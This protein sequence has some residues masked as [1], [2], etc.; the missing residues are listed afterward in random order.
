MGKP[1]AIQD[2]RTDPEEEFE[3]ERTERND[4]GTK[5]NRDR[6]VGQ[7]DAPK[8]RKGIV[9]DSAPASNGRMVDDEAG[10][11]E[12]EVYAKIAADQQVLGG[13]RGNE[14]ALRLCRV[15][16]YD[17]ECSEAPARLKA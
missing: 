16:Q 1:F 14:I 11:D 12:E 7:I 17:G 5:D 3:V 13:K 6:P 8:S 10:Q 2:A 15:V 9:L 4:R